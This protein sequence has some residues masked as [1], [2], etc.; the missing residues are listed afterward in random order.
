MGMEVDIGGS[1][2]KRARLDSEDDDG[3]APKLREVLRGTD[4]RVLKLEVGSAQ[5]PRVWSVLT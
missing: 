1:P 4:A 5:S 2:L 3:V